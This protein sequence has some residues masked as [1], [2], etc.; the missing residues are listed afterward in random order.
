MRV[1]KR[2]TGLVSTLCA[3]ALLA[4]HP[5]RSWAETQSL[6]LT[7]ANTHATLHATSALSSVDGAFGELHGTL[8]YDLSK[9]TCHVDLTMNVSTL[10]VG[11]ALLRGVML[12]GLM[13]DEDD[14]PTMHYTGSCT[15]RIHN[16]QLQTQL[17]GKLTMR[18]QTHPLAFTTV[19]Q[20]TGNTLT[21][22]TSTA[23]FDQRTWGMSTLLHTVD[24]MVTT[25]TIITF[26]PLGSRTPG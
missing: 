11:S 17:V 2:W 18:G 1:R 23:R 26:P 20:F 10:H 24:P 22:I 3:L 6:T 13:L 19:M 14:H 9:Q 7:P 15:P 12:S 4:A 25:Q 16:G 8:V 5:S 21:S